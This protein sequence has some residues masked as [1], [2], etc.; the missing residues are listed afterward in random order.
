MLTMQM[1]LPL[2]KYP[3]PGPRTAV[4]EQFEERL[5][6]INTI[7]ASTLTTNVP[8]WADSCGRSK[9]KDMRRSRARR[10]LS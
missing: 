10:S 4:F 9:L 3:Q 6:G 5:R 8:L 2:T 7:Q 1:V